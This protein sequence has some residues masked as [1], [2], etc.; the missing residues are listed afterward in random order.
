MKYKQVL[1][2]REPPVPFKMN[3]QQ[4]EE[5]K[6]TTWCCIDQGVSTMW[7]N[8]E[9]NIYTPQEVAK[10]MIH[11]DNSRCT[12]NVTQVKFFMEQRLT[13]NAGAFGGRTHTYVKRLAYNER[14][15][16]AFG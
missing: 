10:A 5:S 1:A 14:P 3:E 2:I 8:Y 9:K 12:L 11:I 6:V 13:I 4:M 16:P 15:G 7:A